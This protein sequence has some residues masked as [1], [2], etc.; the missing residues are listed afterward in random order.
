M[1][2][3]TEADGTE[4]MEPERLFLVPKVVTVDQLVTSL[5]IVF[6]RL[7]KIG[8]LYA[9]AQEYSMIYQQHQLSAAIV[10][11]AAQ[12]AAKLTSERMRLVLYLFI[13]QEGEALT[14][15]SLE[16]LL[17]KDSA[18]R[19]VQLAASNHGIRLN[20]GLMDKLYAFFAERR[21]NEINVEEFVACMESVMQVPEVSAR[22]LFRALD[23]DSSGTLSLAEMCVG[24]ATLVEGTEEVRF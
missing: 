21:R 16:S 3:V 12:H 10:D 11:A 7:V 20:R 2:K 5:G 18:M 1:F 14:R 8:V 22:P 15:G 17:P 23:K 24:L 6:G 9:G 13:A 19:A 4:F